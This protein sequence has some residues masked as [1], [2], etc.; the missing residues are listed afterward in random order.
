VGWLCNDEGAEKK[1]RL[2]PYALLKPPTKILINRF[3]K[4]FR[5]YFL[6]RRDTDGEKA[7]LG[8][9]LTCV[10]M[11]ELFQYIGFYQPADKEC[12][13]TLFVNDMVMRFRVKPATTRNTGNTTSPPS[14][15][16]GPS[17]VSAGVTAAPG[18]TDTTTTTTTT[19][20][21]GNDATV[22][23]IQQNTV[24]VVGVSNIFKQFC[25]QKKLENDESN[26]HKGKC[27]HRSRA[28]TEVDSIIKESIPG[29][30][31]MVQ[32]QTGG[33]VCRY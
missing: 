23:N 28:V 2:V 24:P 30:Y 33:L 32:R 26:K 14:G 13:E 18:T 6:N 22:P 9:P 1:C 10:S 12:L 15:R 16:A 20:T 5:T 27:C 4:E 3:L 21:R 19:T 29:I 7:L 8:N 17:A 11:P 25:R 31:I